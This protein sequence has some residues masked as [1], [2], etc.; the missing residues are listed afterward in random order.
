MTAPDTTTVLGSIGSALFFGAVTL[1]EKSNRGA[2]LRRYE[3]EVAL[4][5]L[6][7]CQPGNALGN[8][9]TPQLAS[10]R[11]KQRV[12]AVY[13]PPARLLEAL[14]QCAIYRRR[15]IQSSV[16][17]VFV[18]STAARGAGDA[19]ADDAAAL[20]AWRRR[21]AAA[22][23]Q[24]WLWQ[25]VKPDAWADFFT[26]LSTKVEQGAWVALSL[27]GRSCGSGVGTCAHA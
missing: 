8:A 4:G 15:W 22:E 25:P 2:K 9:R 6:S 11:G 16:T 5:E 23:A 26:G 17:L 27:K 20:D 10:L 19:A 14:E 21:A 12:V 3:R 1:R 24:G 13:G 7:V 18:E